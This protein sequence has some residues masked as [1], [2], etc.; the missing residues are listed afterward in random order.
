MSKSPIVIKNIE[1]SADTPVVCVPIISKSFEEVRENIVNLTN[2]GVRMIEWRV[3]ILEDYTD[4]AGIQKLLDDVQDNIMNTIMLL[5]LRTKKEGGEADVVGGQLKDYYRKLSEIEGYDAIDIQYN[6]AGNDILNFAKKHGKYT[7]Y[8]YHDFAKTPEQ[9]EFDIIL[10]GMSKCD[11]DVLKMAFMPNEDE[12]VK[13]TI[14]FG[15]AA[16]QKA[17]GQVVIISMG[18]KGK[19]LRKNPFLTGSCFTFGCMNGQESAPGQVVYNKLE[20]EVG[21][22]SKKRNVIYLIGYMGTGKST[23]GRELKSRMNWQLVDLDSFIVKTE[24]RSINQIFETDGEDAFRD[25][26]TGALRCVSGEPMTIVS[27]GGGIILRPE[28][29]DFMKSHGTVILLEATP[30]QIYARINHDTSRPLLKNNM[31]PEYIAEMKGKR[32]PL[33]KRAA[34]EVIMTGDRTK[35]D[36]CDEI[37]DNFGA[38]FTVQP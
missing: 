6:D 12:D 23:I 30:E 21:M 3:D 9:G 14:G 13:R 25:K 29:I 15:T 22:A 33:Y 27:C 17:A 36:I 32:D 20:K 16:I 19:K 10:N 37:C 2:D 4:L 34:D 1:L 18:V 8:S 7:I 38:F 11:C 35:I 28:N 5:T 24:E 26:E 31:S